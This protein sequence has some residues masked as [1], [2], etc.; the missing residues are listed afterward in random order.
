[1]NT[2]NQVHPGFPPPRP[3]HTLVAQALCLV[4]HVGWTASGCGS[5]GLEEACEVGDDMAKI[6]A[7]RLYCVHLPSLLLCVVVGVPLSVLVSPKQWPP[8]SLEDQEETVDS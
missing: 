7:L 3:R 5:V 6:G 4:N 2:G 1:M 8:S